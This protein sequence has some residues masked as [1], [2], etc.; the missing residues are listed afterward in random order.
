MDIARSGRKL[1]RGP[2]APGD[3][4]IVPGPSNGRAT[5][6]GRVAPGEMP[7]LPGRRRS[8]P[9]PPGQPSPE[10]AALAGRQPARFDATR[11][12]PEPVRLLPACPTRP[13]DWRWHW[14]G[15]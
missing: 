6:A 4:A 1:A 5:P 10:T 9:R 3:P 7:E 12:G 2:T 11:P 15:H 8:R 13:P 14:A